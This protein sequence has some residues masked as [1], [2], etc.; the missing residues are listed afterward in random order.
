M[1]TQKISMDCTY[2]QYEKYLKDE[3]EKMGYEEGEIIS[4][5]QTVL[6]CN[7]LRGDNGVVSDIRM[8]YCK[9]NKR[10]YLGKF[11]APLF[12]ALAA[13]T[14]KSDAL[15]YREYVTRKVDGYLAPNMWGA[16]KY[17]HLGYHK[18]T[19]EEIMEKFGDKKEQSIEYELN[20]FIYEWEIKD[21]IIKQKDMKEKNCSNCKNSSSGMDIDGKF[22]SC[23]RAFCQKNGLCV[24]KPNTHSCD[25]HEEKNIV[26]DYI[27]QR[28]ELVKSGVSVTLTD[29]TRQCR[30]EFIL[31]MSYADKLKIGDPFKISFR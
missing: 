8:C 12:L 27:V 10:N 5:K 21:N 6:V 1:F 26:Y 31:D 15:G 20:T 9:D 18:S 16:Q 2:E 7:N 4:W 11:N 25:M 14:D 29:K 13:M 19:A 24:E 23:I 3:L 30:Y 17:N 22:G 28:L